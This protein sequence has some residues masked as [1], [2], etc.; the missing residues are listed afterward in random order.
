M[1]PSQSSPGESLPLQ[2]DLYPPTNAKAVNVATRLCSLIAARGE[3]PVY[4][5][6]AVVR[7]VLVI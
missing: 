3:K 6:V 4:V 7:I 1:V 5:D 2:G